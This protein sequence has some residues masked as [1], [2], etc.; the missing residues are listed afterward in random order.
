[1]TNLE[2]FL[3]SRLDTIDSLRGGC[4][5]T[6]APVG[7][8]E[9]PFAIYALTEE[10]EDAELGGSD[11]IKQAKVRLDLFDG[12]NDRL[13]MLTRQVQQALLCADLETD[14][15]YIYHSYADLREKGFDLRTEMQVQTLECRA[16]YWEAVS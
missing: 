12:D 9:P 2:S 15:L 10:T 13:G 6:A 16:V 5:P 3:V 11:G 7:D 1:M 8:T 4:F 14:P